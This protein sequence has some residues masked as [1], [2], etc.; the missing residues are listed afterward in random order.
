MN[1]ILLNILYNCEKAGIKKET[2]KFYSIDHEVITYTVDLPGNVVHSFSMSGNDFTLYQSVR[3]EHLIKMDRFVTFR[4][5]IWLDGS[6]IEESKLY[7][8]PERQSKNVNS[9]TIF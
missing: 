8:N 7:F 4:H 5:R 9:E 6:I 1:K 2:A 3:V